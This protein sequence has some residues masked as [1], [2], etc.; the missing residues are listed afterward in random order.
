MKKKLLTAAIFVTLA[1]A[2][3]ALAQVVFSF[4]PIY[5]ITGTVNDGGGVAAEG[6]TVAFY[7][8]LDE[9]YAGKYTADTVGTGG[10]AAAANRYAVNTSF[11]S[12]L[13]IGQ[14]YFVAVVQDSAGYGAG[15]VEVTVSGAGYDE[16]PAMTMALGAGIPAAGV[17]APLIQQVKFGERVYF[18]H[19]VEQGEKFVTSPTPDIFVNIEAVGTFGI[20]RDNIKII[21][22]DGTVNAKTY[23]MTSANIAS[24]S[25]VAGTSD[26]IRSLMVEYSVP[27]A[28]PLIADQD[29]TVTIRAWDATNTASSTEVCTVTVLGGP[30][31]VVG[32]VLCYPSPF[33]PTKDGGTQVQ[34]TLSQDANVEIIIISVAGETIRR[35][36]CPSGTEGGS[37]GAN[38][39]A[40]DG[41]TQIGEKVGNGVYAG[42]IISRD[43][44]KMLAKFKVTVFD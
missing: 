38:K 28:E 20:N 15:P 43:E 36:S 16:A 9:Y 2:G 25:Y 6:H 30:L 17:E 35:I 37:A 32:G 11:F 31:R 44:N 42:T 10:S 4:Y 18:S 7:R 3:A 26:V 23:T 34:Y 29:N 24:T 27:E 40:W 13:T 22:N 39:V 1:L 19:L 33:S 12:G 41:T 8:T 21:I 14:K 5:W